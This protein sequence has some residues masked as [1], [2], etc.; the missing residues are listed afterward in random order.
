M[1]GP[2]GPRRVM[3]SVTAATIDSFP[4]PAVDFI[5]VRRTA[6]THPVAAVPR[7]PAEDVRSPRRPTR[8]TRSTTRTSAPT[9]RA[10]GSRLKSI[11]PVCPRRWVRPATTCP[12]TVAGTSGWSTPQ[13]PAQTPG[14]RRPRQGRAWPH[15]R[16]RSGLGVV[17]PARRERRPG[18]PRTSSGDPPTDWGSP[19]HPAWSNWSGARPRRWRRHRWADRCVDDLWA[20]CHCRA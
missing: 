16:G 12:L 14:R 20:G 1:R 11:R 17:A 10:R 13:R 7:S 2:C 19:W 5:S 6:A 4:R 9:R 18:P 15:P 8:S 3:P